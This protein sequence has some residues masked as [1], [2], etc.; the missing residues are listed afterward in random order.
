MKITKERANEIDKSGFTLI[1]LLVVIS[2]IALLVSILMP[3][4]G[5]ARESAK[6][7]VCQAS[8]HSWAMVFGLYGADYNDKW[9]KWPADYSTGWWMAK[10]LPYY[11]A[12]DL[13]SCAAAQEGIG[14]DDGNGYGGSKR[15]WGPA[16][17]GT[18]GSYGINHYIYGHASGI[19]T[20]DNEEKYFWGRLGGAGSQ[21][22]VPLL[23]DC[24]W[25]GV[26][27]SFTD[28]VPPSGDE[29]SP[30]QSLGLGV[31]CEMARVCLDRHGRSINSSFVDLS[32][33]QVPLPELW[34]LKWHPLWERQFKTNSDFVDASGR[35][36]LK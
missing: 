22:D 30:T 34:D 3:A 32:C 24:T 25:P 12:D 5:K 36:W 20:N 19:W 16:W 8:L 10:L 28:Q 35:V 18:Y 1:E 31:D 11:E 29:G 9:A 23:M 15:V 14:R 33:R 27:P 13:R 21:E 17:D 4:L 26:F 6:S 7:T 2:I